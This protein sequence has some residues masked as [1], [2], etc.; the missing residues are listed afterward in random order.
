MINQISFAGEQKKKSGFM[1]GATSVLIAGGIGAGVGAGIGAI[2]KVYAKSQAKI[3]ADYLIK[4][5]ARN[6]YSTGYVALRTGVKTAEAEVAAAKSLYDPLKTELDSAVEN[7]RNLGVA[8]ESVKR[9]ANSFEKI[10]SNIA[11]TKK[12]KAVKKMLK[13]EQQI[14]AG[15]LDTKYT[16]AADTLS[17]AKEA[18]KNFRENKATFIED[19]KKGLATPEQVSANVEKFKAL[20]KDSKIAKLAKKAAK[21]ASIAKGAKIG[22]LGLAI[23]SLINVV[24]KPR[25]K[26]V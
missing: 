10:Y 19:I 2:P 26:Q 17:Q 15:A 20:A 22:G 12:G 14:A 25:Q 9:P 24:L 21:G 5:E 1:R 3:G 23:G 7:L 4:S 18:A 11:I 13:L 8:P 16:T 6:V